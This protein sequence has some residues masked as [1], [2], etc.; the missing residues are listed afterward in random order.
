MLTKRLY[1]IPQKN[2]RG[3]FAFLSF[4]VPQN[5]HSYTAEHRGSMEFGGELPP[6]LSENRRATE[7]NSMIY[8]WLKPFSAIPI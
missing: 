6:N 4:F 5:S 2:D 8:V 3:H 1:H 7:R